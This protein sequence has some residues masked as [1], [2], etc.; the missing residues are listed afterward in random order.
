MNK[1]SQ[2][3]TVLNKLLES[4]GFHDRV[5]SHDESAN[6]L[7]VSPDTL[8]TWVSTKRYNLRRIKVGSKNKYWLS[9]LI[10]FLNERTV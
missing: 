10:K 2:H 6:I 5:C 3:N 4:H 8:Y 1:E 9:D 7:G